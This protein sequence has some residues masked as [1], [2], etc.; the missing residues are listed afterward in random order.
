MKVL[1]TGSSGYLGKHLV[2]KLESSG[3]EIF[4]S[5]TKIANLS[6]DFGLRV[7]DNVKFDYI[8]H[9]AA[10]TKAGDYCLFHKGDQWID[11]QVINTNILKY[12]KDHQPQA[13]MI[14]IGTSC[15]YSPE[16]VENMDEKY[17]L[18][19][20]P[21]EGL[22]TYA[23]TK[24]MLLIGL[25][26]LSEQYGLEWVYLIPSTIYG[27]N[28]DLEDSHFIF[29]VIKKTFDGK[30]NNKEVVLWGDGHQKR[31]LVYVDDVVN[32]IYELKD[33]KNKVINLGVGE[34]F[35]IRDYAKYVSDIFNYDSSLIVYDETKYVGVRSK[36][37]NV[38][39]LLSKLPK[40]FKF[41]DLKDGL[42]ITID[43]FLKK[44]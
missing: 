40:E 37:L 23:M 25:N 16:H 12:W 42:K 10:K 28:F 43:Y 32:M 14:A 26:S 22:Y 30:F 44:K 4:I 41:T 38:K 1:V 18:L 19:G 20:D 34:E 7:Y 17:Y 27:P 24:R 11:N 39:N 29:D 33:E 15:S 6:N 31:E 8:F 5:N 21:D 3:F 2:K 9:L 36:K 35:S 13:K